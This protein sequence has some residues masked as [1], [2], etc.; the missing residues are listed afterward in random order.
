DVFSGIGHA[1]YLPRR[2][3]FVRTSQAPDAGVALCWVE[4]DQDHLPLMKRPEEAP[5]EIRGGG[6]GKRQVNGLI[7][8]GSPC[9]RIVCVEVYTPS[10]NWSSFP[11]HKHDERKVDD[12]G[13]I[14][15]ADLEEI[16]FYK[17][18]KPQGYALQQVYTGDRSLDEIIR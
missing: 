12:Q 6:N 3:D 1:M 9:N 10:G 7:R 11:A 15:E 13:E 2:T 4:T 18:D 16:Y 5:N 8:A 17:V 14:L